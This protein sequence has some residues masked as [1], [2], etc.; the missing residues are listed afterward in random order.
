MKRLMTFLFMSLALTVSAQDNIGNL[1]KVMPDSLMPL[2]TRNNRL[3]MI[4]FLEARMKAVVNNR[5]DGESEMTVLTSDSLSVRMSS[6]ETVSLFLRTTSE[7]HDSSR[8]VVCML[9]TYTLPSIGAVETTGRVFSVRW[10]LLDIPL[11]VVGIE[12]RSTVLQQEERVFKTD[13]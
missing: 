13:K 4:D 5:L 12:P 2:L 7:P 11:E 8:Q 6:T 1:F 3:D 10:R 9:T